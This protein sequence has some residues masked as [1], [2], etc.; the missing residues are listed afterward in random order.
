MI[1]ANASLQRCRC[2]PSLGQAPAPEPQS[3][4]EQLKEI[5]TKAKEA[6]AYSFFNL[7][8]MVVLGAYLRLRE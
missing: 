5:N 6:A 8:A 2:S 3:V 1:F 4:S 7:L